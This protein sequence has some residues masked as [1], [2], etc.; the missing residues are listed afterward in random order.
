MNA[1]VL[2]IATLWQREMIR[3]WRER[4]RVL[5]FVGT[6]LVFWLIIGSGF[7]N[8]GFFYPG[9]LTL[10]VMFS[11]VFSM[12]SLIED[13]REGFLLSMLASPAPR[14]AM[15][16]GKIAGSSTLA[17]LQSLI[18]L[19]FLPMTG[20][21]I[22]PLVLLELA[23]ILFLI[24][25][26]FTALGFFFAW[27]MESTQ[28]FH[29]VMNLVLFPLWMISGA[30]FSFES[31]GAWMQVAMRLNPLTYSVSAIRRLLDPAVSP[32]TP[33]LSLS[34]MVTLIC[35]LILLIASTV[36]A[37]RPSVRNRS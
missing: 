15:A 30:L 32:Q 12:M 21:A 1:L 29:A 7:G 36:A 6:P 20:F 2:P 37:S 22:S 5:G 18:F 33:S 26:T 11:A 25:F 34:V 13:R 4:S 3:F 19:A 9:A 27:Q 28:G 10:T 16:F 23:A 17:W 14:S 8:L 24:A 35:G 31:T